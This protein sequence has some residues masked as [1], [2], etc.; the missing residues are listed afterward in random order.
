MAA[1]QVPV[2]GNGH[3]RRGPVTFLFADIRGFTRFTEKYG[4]EAAAWLAHSLVSLTGEVA[5]QHDGRLR[6]SWGDQVLVEFDSPRDAIRAALDLQARCVGQTVRSPSLPL[7]VGVGLDV[8][9]PADEGVNQSA[10]ALN[11]AARLC[12]RAG[13]GEV[14]ATA[15]LVHLAGAVDSSSYLARGTARFKGI[16][17]PTR[18]VLVRSD[19]IDRDENHR[20]R[21]AISDDRGRRWSRGPTAAV[22]ALALVL[23]ALGVTGSLL[24]RDGAAPVLPPG[25]IAVID[26]DSGRVIDA[27]GVGGSPEGL[28]SDGD[29]LWVAQSA[30]DA[31]VRVDRRSRVVEQRVDVGDVPVAV[32]VSGRDVWVV[33]SGD[34][35]VSRINTVTSRVVDDIAVGNQPVALAVGL[36]SVWVANSYDATVSRIDAVTG[37][38]IGSVPVGRGPSGLAV[39][40][41]TVWVANGRDGTVSPVDPETMREGAPI[42]VGAGPKGVTVAASGVWVAN[43]LDLTVTRIDPRTRRPV[44]TIPVGDSPFAVAAHDGAVWVSASASGTLVSVDPTRNEV[45]QPLALGASPYGLVMA[46]GEMWATTR[47]FASAEHF[48]GTLTV[49]GAPA[50]LDP[51]VDYQ[52]DIQLLLYDGLVG[53]RRAGGIDDYDLVPDLAVELPEP[54]DGGRTYSFALR[55]GIRYSDGRL[56]R[57]ADFR[58]GIERTFIVSDGGRAGG[59]TWYFRSLV[60]ADACVRAPSSCDLSDGIVTGKSTVTFRLTEPDPDFRFKLAFPFAAPAPPGTPTRL[61]RP[62]AVLGTGPY[63]VVSFVPERTLE[64]GRNPNF[65]SWSAAAQPAAY[66][67]KILFRQVPPKDQVGQVMRGHLDVARLNEQPADV[68]AELA[69]RSPAQVHA[70]DIALT[71]YVVLDT[72]RPPFNRVSARRA[73]ALAVDRGRVAESWSIDRE[74]VACGLPP[75]GFPGYELYCPFTRDADASLPWR[76]PDVSR[77]RRLVTRSGTEGER[78]EVYWPAQ[79]ESYADTGRY[80]TRLLRTL[81]YDARLHPTD[82]FVQGGEQPR[83]HLTQVGWFPDFPSPRI[84]YDLTLH[85]EAPSNAS[86]SRYCNR[87]LDRMA[88][89]AGEVERT[90]PRLANTLWRKVYRTITDQAVIVPTHHGVS[91]LVVSERVGNYQFGNLLGPH[92]DQMWVR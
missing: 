36:G 70:D 33:N 35:T 46:A 74:H 32:A 29:D 8:G 72:S 90:D 51:A 63:R 91:R 14:L 45:G 64:L 3:A 56:L 77:A 57:P 87:E 40:A 6:G 23:L 13:P 58:R 61:A 92:Y 5:A 53:F 11:R 37:E 79:Q 78:V 28:A 43:R 84:L 30:E 83:L 89:R 27:V 50:T 16:R 26:P 82:G 44:A 60:G 80:I 42:M 10:S 22:L 68:V 88:D 15:E 66:P 54:T 38:V 55:P 31:V 67:D 1:H 65:V 75:P 76:G 7:A 2:A 52:W 85:C 81:G 86:L 69:V 20:F 73:V 62:G 49:A 24:V 18:V 71:A 25:G 48:G 21:A 39:G 9:E 4:A 17:E 47:P 41:R 12:A 59:E 19:R 34:N